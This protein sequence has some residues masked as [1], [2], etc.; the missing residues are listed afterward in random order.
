MWV[1]I[2]AQ[3]HT[4]SSPHHPALTLHSVQDPAVQWL[5]AGVIGG[6]ADAS[7]TAV[8]QCVPTQEEGRVEKG[9][10]R[11]SKQGSP[12][13]CYPPMVARQSKTEE[14]Q[15]PPFDCG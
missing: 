10:V 2:Q 11:E 8:S 6:G 7:S 15:L 12:T 14:S 9:E 1:L 5:P 3:S 4:L 13:P